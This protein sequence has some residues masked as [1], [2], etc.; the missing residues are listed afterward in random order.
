[1]YLTKHGVGV[2]SATPPTRPFALAA[3]TQARVDALPHCEAAGL[4]EGDATIEATSVAFERDGT[5][6]SGLVALRLD[7]RR[8]ALARCTDP[9]LLRAM[10]E[11]TWEGRSVT[12]RNDGSTNT[13]AG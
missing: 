3:D 6:S 9:D 8:R 2:W 13:I 1:W 10:T 11:S 7:E 12:V 5:P 4:V